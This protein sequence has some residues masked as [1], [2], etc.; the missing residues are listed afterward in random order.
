MSIYTMKDWNKDGELT[1]QLFQEVE[2]EIYSDM[3]C[4]LPPYTLEEVTKEILE[5]QSGIKFIQT[6]CVGEE[7]DQDD[8]GNYLY[9]SFGKQ[10]MENVF[11]QVYVVQNTRNFHNKNTIKNKITIKR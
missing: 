10:Q 7:Y 3:Y 2:H 8:D 5:S 1:P 6:F 4:V 9:K 11:T